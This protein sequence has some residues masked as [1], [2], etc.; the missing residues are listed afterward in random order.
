MSVT[1]NEAPPTDNSPSTSSKK[2]L[3]NSNL[4]NGDLNHTEDNDPIVMKCDNNTVENNNQSHDNQSHDDPKSSTPVNSKRTNT[5]P[6]LTIDESE[7]ID[8]GVVKSKPPGHSRKGSSLS[9]VGGKQ[10]KGRGNYLYKQL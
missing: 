10:E 7:D 6:T 2:P 5:V 3:N 9:Q 4:Q 8:E 1:T